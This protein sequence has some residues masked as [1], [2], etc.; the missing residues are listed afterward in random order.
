MPALHP[1]RRGR[2]RLAALNDLVGQSGPG[3]AE[4][5]RS[6]GI[7]AFIPR[8][9]SAYRGMTRLARTQSHVRKWYLCPQNERIQLLIGAG[10]F[11]VMATSTLGSTVAS[12]AGCWP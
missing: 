3:E 5:G 10:G 12:K 4:G 2:N 1:F 7:P 11:G 8:V 6:P 9:L